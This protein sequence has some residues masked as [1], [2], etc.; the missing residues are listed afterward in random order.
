M[1]RSNLGESDLVEPRPLPD[2]VHLVMPNRSLPRDGGSYLSY[3]GST[4]LD[5][6]LMNYG[7]ALN[8]LPK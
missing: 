7:W 6:S 8:L 1:I 4:L 2:L 3:G 5:R